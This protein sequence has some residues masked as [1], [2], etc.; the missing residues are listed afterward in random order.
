M[1][2]KGYKQTEEHIRKVSLARIG[3]KHSKETK[4]KMIK[5]HRIKRGYPPPMLGKNMTEERINQ[6][7]KV[8]YSSLHRWIRKNK[9]KPTFCEKCLTNKPMDVANISQEYKRDI[10]DF[11]WLCRRCHMKSDGRMNN[12]HRNKKRKIENGLLFCSNCIKFLPKSEF[13][14]NKNRIDGHYLL[15][16]KCWKEYKSNYCNKL[17]G[18]RNTSGSCKRH[19]H[20]GKSRKKVIKI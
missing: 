6:K 16:I 1:T 10:N 15:C 4:E 13:Y 11:E 5:N 14:K 3:K 17:L 20:D 8:S 7:D 9:Q 18:Y 2:K 12:L 19:L